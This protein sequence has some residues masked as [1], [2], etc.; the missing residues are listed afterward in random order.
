MLIMK[1][2]LL[3]VLAALFTVTAMAQYSE[4]TALELKGGG[5][6]YT[7]ESAGEYA[8]WYYTPEENTLLTVTPSA[9]YSYA[10]TYEGEGE[11]AYQSRLR[12][13]INSSQ[14]SVYYLEKG[15]KYYFRRV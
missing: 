3:T 4:E 11:T 6:E 13:F 1:K 8:Y 2:H 5:N 14:Y 10:Y 12:S 7:L 15:R 9:G